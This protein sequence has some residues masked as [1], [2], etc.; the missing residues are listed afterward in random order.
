MTRLIST[1]PHCDVDADT[2]DGARE[3]RGKRGR[4]QLAN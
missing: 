2:I 3:G 4:R 1:L